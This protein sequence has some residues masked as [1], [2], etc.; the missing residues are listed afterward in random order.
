MSIIGSA[1]G[2]ETYSVIAESMITP[3]EEF[4]AT[5]SVKLT[6][7][8][9]GAS[10]WKI[11]TRTPENGDAYG[12][13]WATAESDA[14]LENNIPISGTFVKIRP[15]AT[16]KITYNVFVNTKTSKSVNVVDGAGK[17]I[18]SFQGSSDNKIAGQVE[19]DVIKDGTYY[20]YMS[21]SSSLRLGGFTFTPSAGDDTDD[22][23]TMSEYNFDVSAFN[24][25]TG[26]SAK[27][28]NG[29]LNRTAGG[30]KFE[31]TSNNNNEFVKVNNSDRFFFRNGQSGTLAISTDDNNSD[32]N[33]NKVVLHAVT[34]SDLSSLTGFSVTDADGNDLT[35][36]TDAT[37]GTIT[38]TSAVGTS[39]ININTSD[40][41]CAEKNGHLYINK[42]D[43]Y[44][45]KQVTFEKVTPQLAFASTDITTTVGGEVSNALTTTP[46]NFAVT[47]TSSDDAVATVDNTGAVTVKGSGTATITA[48]YDGETS[49]Y[50]NSAEPVSYTLKVNENKTTINV[51]DLNYNNNTS[52]SNGLDRTLSNFVLTFAGGDGC[53]YNSPNLVVRNGS[54]VMT[55]ALTQ[56]NIDAGVTIQRIV[57]TGTLAA[58]VSV[59]EGSIDAE[60]ETWTAPDGGV[61]E[62]T[63]SSTTDNA[64]TFSSMDIVTSKD[65]QNKEKVT[66]T[67][68]FDPS[69]HTIYYGEDIA[70]TDL[71]K[72]NIPAPTTI[73][74]NFVVKYKPEGDNTT[75]A[76]IDESTGVVT[77]GTPGIVQVVSNFNGKKA[78]DNTKNNDLYKASTSNVYTLNVVRDYPWT[79]SGNTLTI[80]TRNGNKRAGGMS[81]ADD[82]MDDIPGL[83][84]TLTGDIQNRWEILTNAYGK[85]NPTLSNGIPQDGTYIVL[86][87][88]LSGT[89]TIKTRTYD[90]HTYTLVDANGN[91]IKSETPGANSDGYVFNAT[92]S[93]GTKYYYYI[94]GNDY[95]LGFSS[96]TYELTQGTTTFNVS[97]FNYA[98]QSSSR[99]QNL[100]RTIGGF[101]FT[102]TGGE[103]IKY[104]ADN[105]FFFRGKKDDG[106]NYQG[107]LT[108]ASTDANNKITQIV[109]GSTTDVSAVTG[110]TVT[111]D[112]NTIEP[113]LANGSITIDVPMGASSVVISTNELSASVNIGSYTI[114]TTAQ[115]SEEP[116]QPVF[117]FEHASL[118]VAKTG[119]VAN[120]LTTTPKNYHVIFSSSNENVATVNAQTGAV[121][122]VAAGTTTITV[123]STATN[124]FK[125][126]SAS[127]TLTVVDDESVAGKTWDFTTWSTTD[128]ETVVND[129]KTWEYN[130]NGYHKNK[131]GTSQGKTDFGLAVMDGLKFTTTGS[132]QI[133]IYPNTEGQTDG[134]IR[135]QSKNAKI[136]MPELKAGQTITLTMMTA[137][138]SSARGMVFSGAGADKVQL[139]YGAETSKT[140]N[141][142]TYRVT[143]DISAEEL[144]MSASTGGLYLYSIKL[145]YSEL[146]WTD[147]SNTVTDVAVTTS[148]E[149]SYT[150]NS[151]TGASYTITDANGNES[152]DVEVVNGKV[153]VNTFTLGKTHTITATVDGHSATLTLRMVNTASISY[154]QTTATGTLGF[155]FVEPVLTKNP[156]G[157]NVVKWKSSNPEV[158]TVVAD[159]GEVTLVGVGTTTITAYIEANNY[160]AYTDA[161]YTLT[162][163]EKPVMVE[164]WTL[165]LVVADGKSVAVGS[166][167]H[168]L[169]MTAA[170]TIKAGQVT[171]AIPGLTLSFGKTGDSDWTVNNT[172]THFGDLYVADAD[173]VTLAEE[174]YI[175]TGGA[176]LGLEPTVNG[177][178]S[179]HAA[180]YKLQGVVVVDKETNTV[181]AQRRVT[182]DNHYDD[183]EFTVPLQADRT[184]YVYNIGN[185]KKDAEFQIY[186]MPVNA[187]TFTPVFLDRIGHVIVKNNEYNITGAQLAD[188]IHDYPTFSNVHAAE[189]GSVHYHSDSDV[190][191]LD[192]DGNLVIDGE[193]T[194]TLQAH[195]SHT[196]AD[197]ADCHSVAQCTVTYT[198]SQLKFS[199]TGYTLA[200]NLVESFTEPTLT[201]PAAL[202]SST[203][204]YSVDNG[205]GIDSN[206]G[207]ITGI[208]GSGKTAT[209]T[210]TI[211]PE[212]IYFNPTATYTITS[213]TQQVPFEVLEE[214]TVPVGTRAFSLISDDEKG[215]LIDAT[216]NVVIDLGDSFYGNGD[217]DKN[218]WGKLSGMT[219][220]DAGYNNIVQKFFSKNSIISTDPGVVKINNRMQIDAVAEGTATVSM[221]SN[222]CTNETGTYSARN[223]VIKI[224]V[225]KD[226]ESGYYESVYKG[227]GSTYRTW[228]FHNGFD[229]TE[230]SS[231]DDNYTALGNSTGEAENFI[232]HIPSGHDFWIYDSENN[233]LKSNTFMTTVEENKIDRNTVAFIANEP[234]NN[235]SL[236]S[237]A[238]NCFASS[239]GK[240][241]DYR[242]SGT[243]PT[244]Q[245]DD[246]DKNVLTFYT[247]RN[248]KNNWEG[249]RDLNEVSDITFNAQTNMCGITG[250]DKDEHVTPYR[251]I[252]LSG[253]A[254]FI[255]VND[256]KP[257]MW[258]SVIADNNLNEGV[259]FVQLASDGAEVQAM[260]Q[261]LYSGYSD[262]KDANLTKYPYN[263]VTN[264][265]PYLKSDGTTVAIEN[266]NVPNI[267]NIMVGYP[268]GMG[269]LNVGGGEKSP[270]INNIQRTYGYATFVSP[271]N[272]DLTGQT[273]LK[274][275]IC[276]YYGKDNNLVHMVQIKHIPANTPVMLKG[277][278]RDMYVL[279]ISEGNK[280]VEHGISEEVFAKNRL[281]GAMEDGMM[282]QPTEEGI[283]NGAVTTWHNMGLTQNKFLTFTVASPIAKGR[284]YLRITQEE[285]EDLYAAHVSASAA[286]TSTKIVFEDTDFDY[287]S[288]VT[289]PTGIENLENVTVTVGD[290]HYYNLNGVRVNGIPTQKG[291]Y[292]RNGKKIVVR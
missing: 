91:V 60:T 210:A 81:T 278:A 82:S 16:G 116:C 275:Y 233:T 201:L 40:F 3:G 137:S 110:F 65:V 84:V 38:I 285:Y 26:I 93:A 109:I 199:G 176:Y 124:Y 223:I 95:N 78:D 288:D 165:S 42:I 150:L 220:S 182:D 153:K 273:A 22:P 256:I 56:Q 24:Y 218:T 148:G 235:L 47:Y 144:I 234:M 52:Q 207:N 25:T 280:P 131:T 149:T 87:P 100:D 217:G 174:S 136:Y 23:V 211:S 127:Y 142:V 179:L 139:I 170:G 245:Y 94:S 51:A 264:V 244:Y 55:V 50:Y 238:T 106:T 246:D 104:N 98:G 286:S 224:N 83:N 258:M 129:D 88:T 156:E 44:T 15:S 62:V 230:L 14:K 9:E 204:T 242:E 120:A 236:T 167:G 163:N 75:G 265:F 99:E 1:W 4:Q 254:A 241:N 36:T 141:V 208:S 287:S 121:T 166:T 193:G 68:T 191:Y 7:G 231:Y 122:P 248:A 21:G 168:K 279:Y 263:R 117:A 54:G 177:V 64:L 33:I 200:S 151:A 128:I 67:I 203:V 34:P 155:S 143:E 85:K 17:N 215:V 253:K 262:S 45:D 259:G 239:E 181:V 102:Y 189:G 73:P 69:E 261:S 31:F 63:F 249:T 190:I 39:K 80:S 72:F 66:P 214:I 158:A 113:V 269:T 119:D 164:P 260:G 46:G 70:N 292:I 171:N 111:A 169:T 266:E 267:T 8:V 118:T 282:V 107:T 101:S 96:I 53:K 159:N 48:S 160:Y 222:D 5:A 89:V 103:A 146:Y 133:R 225:V 188:D 175:P 194:A 289:T 32:C 30:F 172:D 178:L 268:A 6:Y 243:E 71:G 237:T 173:P 221:Q 11:E 277:Y 74:V 58:G 2:Q 12:T 283:H 37:A 77:L 250:V 257:G 27:S 270:K 86:E 183:Y 276:D 41:S 213:A 61:T 272:I 132:D 184:Y 195:V 112:G 10:G 255:R 187:I 115:P 125:A 284:A 20:I 97:D 154:E 185:G 161:S 138:E 79:V 251:S 227:T 76:S 226:T 28:A 202:S 90:N 92:L 219:S 145:G 29:G 186:D 216:S 152:E 240:I 197:G 205:F 130:T 49:Q 108:I 290:G 19:F 274:A 196:D 192:E 105:N 126:A 114:S 252:Q 59:N 43:V 212:N 229:A 157:L 18:K 291:I 209:V 135:L 271:Y 147:G 123:S 134:S 57:F 281:V 13:I 180:Y 162:V 247:F 198:K 228:N 206:T 35:Y 140:M 232:T